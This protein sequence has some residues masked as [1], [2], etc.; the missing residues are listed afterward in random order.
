M[1]LQAVWGEKLEDEL[2]YLNKMGHA[3][4]SL[5]YHGTL[6]Y[7]RNGQIETIEVI[8]KK[9]DQGEYERLVHLSGDAREVVRKG[10][11]VTCY[12]PDSQSVV[13][14]K[15][16]FDNHFLGRL[17]DNFKDFV[18]YY[19]FAIDGEERVAGRMTRILL[20]Q[21]K[22]GYRY[23]YRLWIDQENYL[24]LK[25]E[26]VGADNQVFEQ[27]MFANI[28]VVDEIPA[29]MLVPAIDGDK[30]TWHTGKGHEGSVAESDSDWEVNKLPDG[31]TVTGYFKQPMPN[32]EKPADHLVLS[33]GLASISVYIES[34]NAESQSF[35]GSTKMGAMNVYGTI[36][37]DYKVT[38]VGEVPAKTVHMIAN[39]IQYRA[40][41]G[42]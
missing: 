40:G 42:H 28:S 9:D 36:Q 37:E 30:F 8:H 1:P 32:S 25:S 10:D 29:K 21:P 35:V 31:F 33:D 6:I 12:L 22:D 34:F 26:L 20:V 19:S 41:D 7:L 5:N 23:G 39:A 3:L 38:V 16:R 4:R 11:V 17:K 2:D 13:V 14:G 24:L 15:R 18:D 27:M